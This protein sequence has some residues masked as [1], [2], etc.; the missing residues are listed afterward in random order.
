MGFVSRIQAVGLQCVDVL[1]IRFTL[2]C[3]SHASIFS[4]KSVSFAL[5]FSAAQYLKDIDLHDSKSLDVLSPIKL[6]IVEDNEL[7]LEIVVD[8][9]IQVGYDVQGFD[10]GVSAWH[11]LQ[12]QSFDVVLSDVEMPYLGGIELLVLIQ[13]LD[14]SVPVI[15]LSGNFTLKAA[16][17]NGAQGFVPKPFLR[18]DLVNEINLVINKTRQ[19]ASSVKLVQQ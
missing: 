1:T 11:A 15:L 16:I 6:C 17:E 13:T 10:N 14:K 2:T 7:L 5:K 8:S 18:D 12:T 4:E 3:D 9:L 19:A